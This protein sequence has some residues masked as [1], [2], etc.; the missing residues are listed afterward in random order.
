MT[1]LARMAAF[2]AAENARMRRIVGRETWGAGKG[3]SAEQ[4]AVMAARRKKVR[5]AWRRGLTIAEIARRMGCA[6]NTVKHDL[7]AMGL[8]AAVVFM[9]FAAYPAVGHEWYDLEC[10][11]GRDCAKVEPGTV[12][13][14]PGGYRI[15]LRAG[16]HPMV[17]RDFDETVGWESRKLRQSKDDRWHVCIGPNSQVLYC[18]YRPEPQS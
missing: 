15:T 12:T 11:S 10:C 16:Q 18:V 7:A 14:I 3:R 6:A 4:R 17:T 9:A 5:A 8:R 1:P 13:A 2:A